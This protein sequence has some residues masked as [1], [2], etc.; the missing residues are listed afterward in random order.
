M[1]PKEIKARTRE[2]REKQEDVREE[3]EELAHEAYEDSQ[4]QLG[5]KISTAGVMAQAAAEKL[6]DAEKN[7]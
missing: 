1:K 4:T 2:L 7:S 3:L 5:N 6:R